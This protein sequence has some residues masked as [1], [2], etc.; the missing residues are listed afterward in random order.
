[1]K[2]IRERWVIIRDDK[3]IFCGLSRNYTFKLIEDI[4]GTP[5]KTYLSE[6]KAISSFNSS[7][8]DKYDGIRYKA[9]KVIE[10]IVSEESSKAED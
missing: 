5:I 8:N 10:S 7:W 4:G 3:Y 1:M 6:N 9:V 2:I